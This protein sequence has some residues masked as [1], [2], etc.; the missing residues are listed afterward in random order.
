MAL[1]TDD[2]PVQ[3]IYDRFGIAQ[4]APVPE[5]IQTRQVVQI[6]IRAKIYDAANAMNDRIKDSRELSLALTK[7]EEALMWAGKAIFK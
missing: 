4:D 7:L 2:H 6:E 1:K 5:D 3:E